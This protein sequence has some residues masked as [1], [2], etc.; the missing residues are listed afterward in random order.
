MCKDHAR[1]R[2]AFIHDPALVAVCPRWLQGACDK[3]AQC[4]LQ[5]KVRVR[6]RARSECRVHSGTRETAPWRAVPSGI[7][8]P[9]AP[10]CVCVA[11]WT[12]GGAGCAGEVA[13]MQM[14]GQKGVWGLPEEMQ[15]AARRQIQ[16]MGARR[17]E[18][19]PDSI[20][21]GPAAVLICMPA[22]VLDMCLGSSPNHRAR[23]GDCLGWSRLGA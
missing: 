18:E 17:D 12:R 14:H 11:T 6:V 4:P 22:R 5:H 8:G 23:L 19:M 7:K 3:G 15:G 20:L 9:R 10:S 2:C 21:K 1:G 13:C 16:A